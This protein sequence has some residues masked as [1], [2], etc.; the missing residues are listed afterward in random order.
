MKKLIW[1]P[2]IGVLIGLIF[3]VD[4]PKDI[5]IFI[6]WQS[7]TSATILLLTTPY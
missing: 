7:L 2:F 5:I 3:Q 4:I 6:I 1:I